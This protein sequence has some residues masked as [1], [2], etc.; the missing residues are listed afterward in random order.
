MPLFVDHEWIADEPSICLR[1]QSHSFIVIGVAAVLIRRID[2]V[3]TTH[4]H[5]G[6]VVAS[7]RH[8]C[9]LPWVKSHS[10]ARKIWLHI[11]LL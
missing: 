7:T 1:R 11:Y 8:A 10:I 5:A 6:I 2:L 4:G 3:I 9:G